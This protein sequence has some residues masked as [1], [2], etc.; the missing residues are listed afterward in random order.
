MGIKTDEVRIVFN[1]KC[2]KCLLTVMNSREN[3]FIVKLDHLLSNDS[4]TCLQCNTR[5]EP[6]G[7][8]SIIST[9]DQSGAK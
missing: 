7:D 1:A 9:Y 3:I 5:L 6:T 2:P 4:P 8:V